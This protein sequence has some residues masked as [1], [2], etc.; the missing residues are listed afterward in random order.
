MRFIV[1]RLPML[2]DEPRFFILDTMSWLV[3]HHDEGDCPPK[4]FDS[5]KAA[6]EAAREMNV[7][8]SH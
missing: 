7:N 1:C 3:A 6:L 8:N 2:I 4:R 5:M